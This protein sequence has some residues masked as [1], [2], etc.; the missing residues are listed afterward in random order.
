MGEYATWIINLHNVKAKGL[1]VLSTVQALRTILLETVT[2]N[3]S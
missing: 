1:S 2:A 3:L